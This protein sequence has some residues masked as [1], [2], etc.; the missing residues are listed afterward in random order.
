M[1]ALE[2]EQDEVGRNSHSHSI[3]KQIPQTIEE[4]LEKWRKKEE[5]TKSNKVVCETCGDK[6]KSWINL[7]LI[8]GPAILAIQLKRYKN[9]KRSESEALPE[10]IKIKTS[11]KDCLFKEIK[12]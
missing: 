7:E 10:A 8:E 4:L 12:S 9:K 1:I 6:Q 5:L 2:M 3:K 11:Y